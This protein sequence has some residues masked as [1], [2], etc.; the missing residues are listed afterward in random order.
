MNIYNSDDIVLTLTAAKS[1]IVIVKH[2]GGGVNLF[3]IGSAPLC[4]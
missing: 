2:L 3:N 1:V 4:L